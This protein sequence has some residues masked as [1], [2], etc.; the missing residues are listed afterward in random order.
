V[1]TELPLQSHG[2][3]FWLGLRNDW[4]HTPLVERSSQQISTMNQK[5]VIGA[6]G[7]NGSDL[8]IQLCLLTAPLIIAGLVLLMLG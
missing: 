2:W 1:D 4:S 6:E 8:I 5:A 7:A 3:K